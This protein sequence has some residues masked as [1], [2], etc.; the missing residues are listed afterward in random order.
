MDGVPYSPICKEEFHMKR[1]ISLLLSLIIALSPVCT[2]FADFSVP[3]ALTVIESE[4][5]RDM[6]ISGSVALP[7]GVK[8]IGDRA[9]AN[10]NVFSMAM[11]EGLETIGDGILSGTDAVY[12]EIPGADTRLTGSSLGAEIMVGRGGSAAH[13]WADN[14]GVPFLTYARV[15]E[16]DGFI[17][18]Y[19]NE[20]DAAEDG[21]ES[22]GMYLM[23]PKN[24]GISGSVT[25]PAEVDGEPLLFVSRYA[26]AR[27]YGVTEINLPDSAEVAPEGVRVNWPDA[28]VNMYPTAEASVDVWVIANEITMPKEAI[29]I[30]QWGVEIAGLDEQNTVCSIECDNP[31]IIDLF[32]NEDATWFSAKSTGEGVANITIH[33]QNGEFADTETIT[34]VVEAEEEIPDLENA[35]EVEG[36]HSE[37]TLAI[38]DTFVLIITELLPEIE[39]WYNQHWMSSDEDVVVCEGGD[40]RVVGYGEADVYSIM[41]YANGDVYYA[42]C[43]V[44]VPETLGIW[45][46]EEAF[47]MPLG[48]IAIPQWGIEGPDH[49]I[50]NAELS[51]EC[52][53]PEVLDLH[54]NDAGDW[55]SAAS[56]RE[57]E[58]A[59]TIRAQYGDLYAEKTI[60][61]TVGPEAQIPDLTNATELKGNYSEL[62][63]TPGDTFAL[64]VEEE[65]P[66][67]E[68]WYN[69]QWM[70]DN[71][72]VVVTDGPDFRVVGFGEAN[73][74][75]IMTLANGG[76][77]YA[78]AHVTS[79]EPDVPED[80]IEIPLS[81][82]W[83]R[84]NP[85]DWLG[86]WT[87]EHLPDGNFHSYMLS[88]NEDVA[89]WHGDDMV[90]FVGTGSAI[91]TLVFQ[92]E[93]GECF[94][95]RC[96]VF[97]VDPTLD[98]FFHTDLIRIPVG[99]TIHVPWDW[100]ISSDLF[101][102][103][104][105][106]ALD[107][108]A[109]EDGIIEAEEDQWG[110]PYMITGL[111]PGVVEYTIEGEVRGA[112][113]S[114]TITVEVY[115][116]EIVL[117]TYNVFGYTG[118]KYPLIIE[119]EIPE[120]A[121][122]AFYSS[123][124]NVATV[125]E[126]GVVTLHDPN[127]EAKYET[128]DADITCVV[129]YEEN[130]EQVELSQVCRFESVEWNFGFRDVDMLEVGA[131]EEEPFI[132]PMLRSSYWREHAGSYTLES[133]SHNPEILTFGEATET[134]DAVPQA[135]IHGVGLAEV[136]FKASFIPEEGTPLE[137]TPTY[138]EM[139][140]P[141]MI[142]EPWLE[143]YLHEGNFELYGIG[144]Y[145]HISFHCEGEVEP[146]RQ[147]LT[148]SDP[149]IA[150][151]TPDGV[152]RAEGAGT[153]T[154]TYTVE[155][156][157]GV[158]HSQSI[159]VTV[160]GN[161]VTLNATEITLKKGESFTLVPFMDVPEG[162]HVDT[163]FWSTNEN[164][165]YAYWNGLVTGIA[166][167]TAAVMFSGQ[168]GDY[169]AQVVCI[170]HVVDED[171]KI[172]LSETYK[173]LRQGESFTLIPSFPENAEVTD[174]TFTSDD[175][176]TVIVDQNGVVTMIGDTQHI[177]HYPNIE[178]SAV[179][180]GV[181]VSAY[182]TVR[183][184]AT[185][186][187]FGGIHSSIVTEIGDEFKLW[188][189][190]LTNGSDTPYTVTFVSGNEDVLEVTAD[191]VV[192]AVGEGE[193]T[194]TVTL[195]SADDHSVIYDQ[196][197]V[198]V[199]IGVMPKAIE[200][201]AFDR[202][203]YF[204][205]TDE[206][207]QSSHET[208]L[209]MIP[210][211]AW[212]Y[213]GDIRYEAENPDI[214]EIYD[215][216]RIHGLNEGT[217]TITATATYY[218]LEDGEVVE[219][220]AT[221]SAKVTVANLRLVADRDHY[222][223][224]DIATLTLE[225]LP[226]DLDYEW[227]EWSFPNGVN[228]C[229]PVMHEQNMNS[230][231]IQ[232]RVNQPGE[233]WFNAD[234][235]IDDDWWQNYDCVI[236]CDG[237]WN[238]QILNRND[239]Y[240]AVGDSTWVG[241]EYD[242]FQPHRTESTNTDVVTIADDDMFMLTAVGEGTAEV[243]YYFM[244]WD[245]ETQT[246]VE[247]VRTAYI[248][249]E[250]PVWGVHDWD[251]VPS[252]MQ[253]G[254]EY[255]CGVSYWYNGIDFEQHEWLTLSDDSAA[256]IHSENHMTVVA[257]AP[258]S[259][260]LT[261]TV[262]IGGETYT[263]SK[264]I[265]VVEPAVYPQ[266]DVVE[267]NPMDTYEP[268]LIT[269]GGAQIESVKWASSDESKASVDPDSGFVT[270][271]GAFGRAVITAEVTLVGGEMLQ[272]SYIV[273]IVH[274]ELE[275]REVNYAYL[276]MNPGEWMDVWF[277]EDLPD[278]DG[279]QEWKWEVSEEGVLVMHDD[280]QFEAVGL[281][282]VNVTLL[283]TYED[284]RRFYGVSRVHV[285]PSSL[286]IF[287]YDESISIPVGATHFPAWDFE[288]STDLF[289]HGFD[290][291][292]DNEDV[293]KVEYDEDQRTVWITGLE[294]GKATLYIYG[295]HYGDVEDTAS[296]EVEVYQ[297]DVALNTYDIWGYTGFQY[298][299]NLEEELNEGAEV[300][301]TSSDEWLASVDENGLVTV[302]P[303]GGS[304]DEYDVVIT[305]EVIEADGSS[306]IA[307][308]QMKVV[309][310]YFEFSDVQELGIRVGETGYLW[311]R[312][313]TTWWKQHTECFR[314]ESV[315]SN[316]DVLT[317]TE[318][319][320]TMNAVPDATAH[321]VGDG[322]V[323]VT[324]YASFNP[325]DAIPMEGTETSIER[326]M[327]VQIY[328]P[329]LAPQIDDD[330]IEFE[331]VGDGRHLSYW[332]ERDC[333]LDAQ[334]LYSSDPSVVTI[335]AEGEMRAVAPGHATITYAV[336]AFGIRRE[337]SV[338][339]YVLGFGV[340]LNETEITI[341]VGETFCFVPETNVPDDRQTR[342]NF[343]ASS[344]AIAYVDDS[345]MV[346]GLAAGRT[347]V[348]YEC[349]VQDWNEHGEFWYTE[350]AQCIVNVVDPQA[351][352]TL[353][354]NY[355]ELYIGE[356]F[357]LVP[358]FSE[359][360]EVTEL[361][362]TSNDEA[363]VTVDQSG[364]VT[365][366]Q[367]T[368]GYDHYPTVCVSAKVNGEFVSA[369]CTVRG[370]VVTV[371]F[372]DFDG[373]AY[374]YEGQNDYYI[375]YSVLTS[376]P[377]L[378]YTVTFES[379]DE[380]VV[381]VNAETGEL[382]AV[383]AGAA[384]VILSAVSEDGFVYG[385]YV[386]PVYVE[387][388]IPEPTGIEFEHEVYYGFVPGYG[389]N[390]IHL[391]ASLILDSEYE[392]WHFYDEGR[393]Q[394]AVT[395]GEGVVELAGRRL[396]AI[397]EGEAELT[398]TFT[399]EDADGEKKQVQGKVKVIV[400]APELVTD[401]ESYAV[402]EIATITYAGI[403][404][405]VEIKEINW[406]YPR[407]SY[408]V[409]LVE[410]DGLTLKVRVNQIADNG[411]HWVNAYLKLDD[412]L[413]IEH[414]CA[415]YTHGDWN[416][417]T[418]GESYA[419]VVPGEEFHIHPEFSTNGYSTY[420]DDENV[421]TCDPNDPSRLT[422]QGLGEA[423]VTYVCKVWEDDQ[424]IEIERTV[425]V[426]VVEPEWEL[427]DGWY[428]VPAVMQ[429]GYDYWCG[430]NY[431]FNGWNGI[432]QYATLTI[433]NED[434][435][436]I[437]ED[438]HLRVNAI[439]EGKVT[440][441]LNIDYAGKQRTVS[442][443]VL[444]I[445]TH[446]RPENTYMEV[447]PNLE[448]SMNLIVDEGFEIAA[449]QWTISEDIADI[450]RETGVFVPYDTD[451]S[452]T[453]NGVITLNDGSTVV[454]AYDIRVIQ[455]HEIW[456]E[457]DGYNDQIHLNTQEYG[458]DPTT[459][460]LGLSF[461]TN[462]DS[463][464]IH[465]EW[466]ADDDSLFYADEVNSDNVF[467]QFE[468]TIHA[469]NP[470]ETT[471]HCHVWV[472]GVFDEWFDFY[473]HV[474]EPIISM[475]PDQDVYVL[476]ANGELAYVNWNDDFQH[477]KSVE[478]ELM[479]SSDESVVY[480][481]VS[482]NIIPCNVGEATVTRRVF[483][484]GGHIAEASV[485]V[486]V[487][488][489]SMA[490][491]EEMLTLAVGETYQLDYSYDTTHEDLEVY[492]YI[493]D[494]SDANV[495]YVDE[496]GVVHA[497]GV[498]TAG[499]AFGV[500]T[501]YGERIDELILTVTDENEPAFTISVAHT[502]E[503]AEFVGQDV[504]KFYRFMEYQF[505]H[506]FEGQID[507]IQW[508]V[509]QITGD[510]PVEIDE[511]GLLTI[512][513]VRRMQY[514]SVVC[515]I[516]SGE[517][518]YK[519]TF[520]I[521]IN[522]SNIRIT[523]WNIDSEAGAWRHMNV[524]Q[525]DHI[526][527]VIMFTDP[528]VAVMHEWYSEDEN[529]VIVDHDGN[530]RATGEGETNVK[531][532]VWTS[533]G[534]VQISSARV[535]VYPVKIV[536][537]VHG[538]YAEEITLH[539]GEGVYIDTNECGVNA[540]VKSHAF[541]SSDES[542]V[543]V[544]VHGNI[545]ARSVGEATITSR[546]FA[547]NGV[548]SAELLVRVVGTSVTCGE[549]EINLQV[550]DRYWLDLQVNSTYD[551]LVEESCFFSTSDASVASVD[552]NGTVYAIGAG[553]A[554]IHY[555]LFTNH[556][557]AYGDLVVNV[558]EDEQPTL[559]I[560]AAHTPENA[561]VLED[562]DAPDK[563]FAQMP[564]QFSYDFDGTV[565][566]VSWSVWTDYAPIRIND[567]G[568][569]TSDDFD[570]VQPCI[571][572][573]EVTSG[574]KVYTA[575]CAIQMYP[576]NLRISSNNMGSE[577]G[578]WRYHDVGNEDFVDERII[579]NNP[580]VAVQHL[581]ESG[582]HGV[583]QIDNDGYYKAVGKGQT[584]V[585]LTAW[586]SEG[587]V[588]RSYLHFCVEETNAPTSMTAWT[589]TILWNRDW[590]SVSDPLDVQPQYATFDIAYAYD[591][592]MFDI[593]DNRMFHPKQT[594]RTTVTAYETN[595]DLSASWD[596]V[597]VD[598]SVQ[599]REKDYRTVFAPG[600]KIQLVF[601]GD[602]C[603]FDIA[604]A[605]WVRFENPE[606]DP[607]FEIDENG[608]LTIVNPG[609]WRNCW[610]TATVGC[611]NGMEMNFEFHFSINPT[612]YFYLSLDNTWDRTPTLWPGYSGSMHIESNR[613]YVHETVLCVSDNEAVAT[614]DSDGVL[615]CHSAG[616]ATLTTT[617]ETVDGVQLRDEMT[618]TVLEPENP[619]ISCEMERNVLRVGNTV[620]VW[621]GCNDPY[622]VVPEY[623]FIAGDEEILQCNGHQDEYG[624]QTVT[625]V[626]YGTTTLTAV[627]HYGDYEVSDTTTV[628]V[629]AD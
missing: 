166:E 220:T 258:G 161:K 299:L 256:H 362:F 93:N 134:I 257:H 612:E 31:D 32:V 173:E 493:C 205:E 462:A 328:E 105:L 569:V 483:F 141:V 407:G 342:S 363:H 262:E 436:Q 557:A 233:Y 561:A 562:Y 90:E 337:A 397:E 472:D 485:Q 245:D 628:Y 426:K 519:A 359:G 309:D 324:F 369:Y 153:A 341:G 329:Y 306:R 620:C 619:Q 450:D 298:Q 282:T 558:A 221:A 260:T 551:D 128:F 5:F 393:I 246:E 124:E 385:Q 241:P 494:T 46:S 73:V 281:G 549:E 164:V 526:N 408:G 575:S 118:F 26:F 403:P 339:V 71:E 11:P 365:L 350:R 391:N 490:I 388:A 85:G 570:K 179:V 285:V 596:Y 481:D 451:G 312:V 358:S 563:F 387:T 212:K 605:L 154:I 615:H 192:K 390:E 234:L 607:Y 117:N 14:N 617:A 302:H 147:Y 399:Y 427:Q 265:L 56:L 300:R 379:S 295:R 508:R 541:Y 239:V 603:S 440:L 495:G 270:V 249:V 499:I 211:E 70:S 401:K 438:D 484:E 199:Y 110:A 415:I 30:P 75:S 137:G 278:C 334:Y 15:F 225:G 621:I 79:I 50:E 345:G 601:E 292:T 577:P 112:F 333:D 384:E 501:N 27:Q 99:A 556:D 410:E 152:V 476:E 33:A 352:M 4:A 229:T 445:R 78:K 567:A 307:E 63:L 530:L 121:H 458:S 53:D 47:T 136:T 371:S 143:A 507:D 624:S 167:G 432:D 531:L 218:A 177:T 289:E 60:T 618:I 98:V 217:T 613:E 155:W 190:V 537:S 492:E 516:T 583:I 383:G 498:G 500:N 355:K 1:A 224:G 534:E 373:H 55:F 95:G 560:S 21:F 175:E 335:S 228:E 248:T 279:W 565:D 318:P 377:E 389:D 413:D 92:Y 506:D 461:R 210:D 405:D 522:V 294:P 381:Q 139:T 554:V 360:A 74:Y 611:I 35:T 316:E 592:A 625:A 45:V 9:F 263:E 69:H 297:P 59:I 539:V 176:G 456:W 571:V 395:S 349:E 429:V 6:P 313:R 168:I 222:E 101:D 511:N 532:V 591:T 57:G 453:I 441:T 116:P 627:A 91:V 83:L 564:Y 411:E 89:I 2:A 486:I 129:S 367:G 140:I 227:I 290:F 311:P 375:H 585:T 543:D 319:T 409:S 111:K 315:S 296:I 104:E 327:M 81:H 182:C 414:G 576:R 629:I 550:G 51:I 84:V 491:S 61:I 194:L 186:V 425:I 138:A 578:A 49:V 193:T 606:G 609:G 538:R 272:V 382:T 123:D 489:V 431:D 68:T 207:Q 542:V 25:I 100:H 376:D 284:G 548:Y 43:H 417:Y 469:V 347:I 191:G 267:L 344:D 428:N 527:E 505:S 181:K 303:H 504:A 587:E 547:E 48:A 514:C 219:K 36:E 172:T 361:T 103:E 446:V 622:S 404:E 151:V 102:M 449:Q 616:T 604:D 418:L 437:K 135:V 400:L 353:S 12:V 370:A 52:S 170:V 559:T 268:N 216:G 529:I 142:H 29:A 158:K 214:V 351:L 348:T 266:W 301:F 356:S 608:V 442:K 271:I 125:D 156:K 443:Q 107:H 496:N 157:Y 317:F 574:D 58:A 406:G 614:V 77:F 447:R 460:T 286:D 254:R 114:E 213:W 250:E 475:N 553:S 465:V 386:M 16:Q 448:Y 169:E 595:T 323:E 96:H 488:G 189:E 346:T 310:W 336:E 340:S 502:E 544:D 72:E 206:G 439:G 584:D 277:T 106:G 579:F 322:W 19:M 7:D 509:E 459:E 231:T 478:S 291:Y 288:T 202:D 590:G 165:A 331:S 433:D 188:Y 525:E 64:I 80:A 572:T 412:N 599:L 424:E 183:S 435:L 368:G 396:Y 247:D 208:H 520:P 582:D 581:W 510:M 518:V 132:W 178:V 594:G 238:N 305:C 512:G 474:H 434:V 513:E 330:Y 552:E 273:E 226:E 477:C 197:F 276:T 150:S 54:V 41:N 127:Q 184:Y 503:N 39:T 113:D 464:E 235:R 482:G 232:V 380:D 287:F 480:A 109:S 148:S 255:W 419:I 237:E 261:V 17:Y 463:R 533:D 240:M 589:D 269:S 535:F 566:S 580:D 308:C 354:E 10:T 275:G 122:V 283:V 187:V 145:R 626:M 66:P 203:H 610:L 593:D 573:C 259:F 160:Y 146:L 602:G 243:D 159:E 338:E 120:N 545:S 372:V 108:F 471:Y 130:G 598:G 86:L 119:S 264:E 24:D 76:V 242:S 466:F 588:A 34:L 37:M 180:D 87:D 422:A 540:V 455:N 13:E 171:A 374:M 487:N 332:C 479:M 62:T 528:D 195:V 314:F 236:Y 568:L 468:R 517:A 366:I 421:V 521:Q 524:G 3:A 454:V 126:D 394:Y 200:S 174:I 586:T 515:E 94:Y 244:R 452:A 230:P 546:I 597:I 196:E 163:H 185:P 555:R 497:V 28:S 144:D 115:E 215:D 253:V 304:G 325:P 444:V 423:T 65:I 357:T 38:D 378:D 402:G 293:L 162:F 133:V 131:H 398:A 44:V 223:P 364:V 326:T 523:N 8:S 392:S 82:D 198:P 623:E 430:P 149:S 280:G 320:Y 473:V 209:E 23:F 40:F 470:G 251:N 252:V 67:V 416:D 274:H 88:S 201:L 20:T 343:H 42:K 97:S 22:A 600:E 420:S 204:M 536:I 18:A 321:S 457:W 467:D